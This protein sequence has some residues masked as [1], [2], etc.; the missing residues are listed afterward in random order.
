MNYS[1]SPKNNYFDCLHDLVLTSQNNTT[2]SVSLPSGDKI[3]DSLQQLLCINTVLLISKGDQA[4][5]VPMVG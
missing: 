1:T 3:H 4:V 5:T 2:L